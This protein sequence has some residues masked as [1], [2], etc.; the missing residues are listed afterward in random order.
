MPTKRRS[1]ADTGSP[2]TSSPHRSQWLRS[3]ALSVFGP[4][5]VLV[6][7]T[8]LWQLA[9]ASGLIKNYVLPP[10]GD[11]LHALVDNWPVYAEHAMVTMA[12]AVLGFVFGNLIAVILAVIFVHSRVAERSVYPLTLA[13]RSIPVVALGPVLVLWLGTG[14]A[15]KV[16]I[17]S[18]LVFFP[19]LVNMMRGLRAVQPS[20]D[21]L[22]YTLS[23][24]A[25]ER[26][27]MLRFPSSLPFLFAALKIAAGT[28]ILGAVVAEWIGSDQ[29]L[30]YLV[31]LY[32]SQYL[33]PE[34]WGAVAVMAG[35]SVLFFVLISAL[36]WIAIPWARA[37]STQVD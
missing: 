6:L 29:G 33:V 36:E 22:F 9:S 5:V 17:A 19:T 20:A 3:S 24:N 4:V 37:T 34:L 23:A 25:R 18:F 14:L 28:C 16:M 27:L 7:I 30:G 31:V 35:A 26:L 10:P 32:G 8:V 11:V 2:K 12:E 21:E 15:P 13:A 1:S